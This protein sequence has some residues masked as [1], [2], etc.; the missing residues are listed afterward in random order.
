MNTDWCGLGSFEDR[1]KDTLK[2]SGM[3][4]SPVEIEN[5]LLAHPKKWISDVSVAGVSG[6]RTADEKVPRAWIVLSDA[7]KKRGEVGVIKDLKIWS[8]QNL[9]KYKWLRGG[10]EVVDA[11]SILVF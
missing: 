7:G 10:F 8:E 6:G 2:V 1:A 9:S 11:V 4:V 5:T 3:Q